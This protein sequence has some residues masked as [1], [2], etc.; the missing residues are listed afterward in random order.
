MEALVARQDTV[1]EE[2]A[3]RVEQRR[4]R[5]RVHARAE[6]ADVQLVEARGGAQEAARAGPQARV[7]PG[8]RPRPRPR[9]A[10][11]GA[12][13]LEVVHVL[14]AQARCGVRRAY[15]G[16]DGGTQS[17]QNRKHISCNGGD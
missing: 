3:G 16:V 2:R 13:Q 15:R 12:R 7:V 9:A 5:V 1:R 6:R 8:H 4:D 10:R 17:E 14:Q 11:V